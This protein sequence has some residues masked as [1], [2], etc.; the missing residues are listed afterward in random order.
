M[1]SNRDDFGSSREGGPVDGVDTHTFSLDRRSRHPMTKHLAPT[2]LLSVGIVLVCAI[3]LYR[4][5]PPRKPSRPQ[6]VARAEP[7]RHVDVEPKAV[8]RPTVVRTEV[9]PRA[10]TPVEARPVLPTSTV[11]RQVAQSR[12]RPRPTPTPTTRGAF[13]VV[14]EGETLAD[15]AIRVYGDADRAEDL[16]RSNRD[17][18]P[19]RTGLLRTGM[20][21][22]TP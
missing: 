1:S 2:Y 20:L 16:W 4:S 7:V 17:Q 13:T 22:R 19:G 6:A 12:P 14:E 18:A 15:V 10:S 5:D 11:V 21:L 3:A 9:A 8:E